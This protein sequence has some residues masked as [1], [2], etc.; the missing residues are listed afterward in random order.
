VGRH[1][2]MPLQRHNFFISRQKLPKI[3]R[4]KKKKAIK[5]NK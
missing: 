2:A 4:N 3:S 1:P 5:T